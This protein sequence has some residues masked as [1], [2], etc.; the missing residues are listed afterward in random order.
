MKKIVKTK[1]SDPVWV[2]KVGR[3]VP[4]NKMDDARLSNTLLF[5]AKKQFRGEQLGIADCL[6][7]FNRSLSE[8]I[9]L[10]KKEIKLRNSVKNKIK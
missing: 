1:D 7:Y 4:L 6:S 10:F 5:L 9:S 8:W 2:D 3:I